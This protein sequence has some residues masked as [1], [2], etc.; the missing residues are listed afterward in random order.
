MYPAVICIPGCYIYIYIY[1]YIYPAVI[2][3]PGGGALGL[4]N[5]L[6]SSNNYY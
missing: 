4:D 3:I 5:S 6:F 1:I 2:Y